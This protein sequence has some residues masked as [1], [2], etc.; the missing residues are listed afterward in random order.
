ML[1]ASLYR[2]VKRFTRTV[3]PPQSLKESV[4]GWLHRWDFVHPIAAAII[5]GLQRSQLKRRPVHEGEH[6][7]EESLAVLAFPDEIGAHHPVGERLE[8][9]RLIV[10]VFHPG[11]H[12]PRQAVHVA[13]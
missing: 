8:R 11:L 9:V 13:G 1:T 5:R 3:M 2:Q 10:V 6:L 4:T 7:R 12:L